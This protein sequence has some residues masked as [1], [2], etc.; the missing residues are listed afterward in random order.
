MAEEAINL[1]AHLA[2]RRRRTSP[3]AIGRMPPDLFLIAM[4]LA[5]QRKGEIFFGAR[6][7]AMRLERSVRDVR[8]FSEA[9]GTG[10]TIIKESYSKQAEHT[11]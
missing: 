3:T 9:V 4:R 2:T 8:A 7:L 10:K 6:P 1:D 5:P 11:V